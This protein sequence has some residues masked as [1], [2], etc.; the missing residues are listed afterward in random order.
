MQLIRPDMHPFASAML[1][2]FFILL[3]SVGLIACYY[4]IR[5][6][7]KRR[8][9]TV[10][11]IALIA[12]I[13]SMGFTCYNFIGYQVIYAENAAQ[14]SGTFR[15][16]ESN[17]VLRIFPNNTWMITTAQHTTLTK[18]KWES[19]QSEDGC[20]CNLKSDNNREFIQTG[21]P[22]TVVF[23]NRQLCFYRTLKSNQK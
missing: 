22:N 9:T 4:G 13:T 19:I 16:R 8:H 6:L 10:A 18:G 20:Y 3:G 15:D 17:M 11:F 12:G 1:T 7:R 14:I 23:K 5:S 21:S 2:L